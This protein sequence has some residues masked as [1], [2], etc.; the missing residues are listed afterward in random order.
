MDIDGD[1]IPEML[2]ATGTY[3]Q[4]VFCFSGANGRIIWRFYGNDAFG[5][6]CPIDDVNDDGSADVLAGVW[7]N[8]RDRRIY[9]ISGNSHGNQ[10]TVLWLYQAEGDVYCVRAISDVNHSGYSDVIASTWG[11][12][13]YCLEGRNGG[14]IWRT[15][16]GTYGMKVE[17]L[18]DINADTVPEVAIGSWNPV[19]ILLD[20]KTGKELWQTPVGNDVWTVYPLGDVN[21]DGMP[22]LVAGSGDGNIYC[23]NGVNGNILWNYATGGWVNSARSIRDVNADGFD[24]VIAGNQFS[25]TPG[26]VYCVEGDGVVTAIEEKNFTARITITTTR[27]AGRVYDSSGRLVNNLQRGIFFVVATDKGSVVRKKLL[28]LR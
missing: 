11:N 15:N 27:S 2:A 26:Y 6:V 19:V 20:G 1:S 22:D 13:V 5:S 9:C 10:P 24:E 25:G 4:T 23:V 21:G 14:L 17:L 7:G 18:G 8:S 28:I 3:C 12:Y 16:I